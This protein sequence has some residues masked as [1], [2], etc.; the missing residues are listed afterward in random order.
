MNVDDL[1]KMVEDAIDRIKKTTPEE[2]EK[3][4]EKFTSPPYDNQIDC[5]SCG[6]PFN[7]P[8]GGY[9]GDPTKCPTC[10][11]KH[12]GWTDGHTLGDWSWYGSDPCKNCQCNPANGGSGICNCTLSGVKITC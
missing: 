2:W 4:M 10:Q 11:H 7:P 6:K 1:D 8:V 12:A 3:L 5:S 9:Y